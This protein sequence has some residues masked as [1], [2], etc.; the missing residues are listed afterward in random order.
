MVEVEAGRGG[1]GG[2]EE[3]DLRANLLTNPVKHETALNS[4]INYII[5]KIK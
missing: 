5:F 3:E 2:G 1:G 4:L